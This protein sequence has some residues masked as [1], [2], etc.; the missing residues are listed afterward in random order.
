MNVSLDRT[1]EITNKE[2]VDIDFNRILEFSSSFLH[3]VFRIEGKMDNEEIESRECKT[4]ER[5]PWVSLSTHPGEPSSLHPHA[6]SPLSFF[7]TFFL[8][9]LLVVVL[10]FDVALSLV[11]NLFYFFSF[12]IIS[13]L[14]SSFLVFSR[15]VFLLR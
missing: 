7:H 1:G 6:R 2:K 11:R 9:F 14:F 10:F 12:L 8:V 3:R 5:R 4:Y 13:R 15:L